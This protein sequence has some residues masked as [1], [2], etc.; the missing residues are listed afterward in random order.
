[1]RQAKNVEN[2]ILYQ[3]GEPVNSGLPSE[4]ISFGST[5]M[6]SSVIIGTGL[7]GFLSY[8]FIFLWMFKSHRT[9]IM[10][11]SLVAVS[12]MWGNA[13]AP[14]VWWYICLGVSMSES[15]KKI[16]K[17]RRLFSPNYQ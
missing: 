9:R 13:F 4:F 1:M 12:F 11:K 5:V 15:G 10:G 2:R 16:P 6:F 7:I 17:S 3:L 8:A 14:M